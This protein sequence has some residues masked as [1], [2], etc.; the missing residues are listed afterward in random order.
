MY[1]FI[2]ASQGVHRNI[3]NTLLTMW[4]R[5]GYGRY[6]MPCGV[7]PNMSKKDDFLIAI[8]NFFKGELT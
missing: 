7:A 6:K 2:F 5:L 4:S 8:T 3:L 1:L